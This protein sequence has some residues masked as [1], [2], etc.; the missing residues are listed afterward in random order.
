LIYSVGSK[1]NYEWEDALV[2]I[3]GRNHCEIHV[4]GTGGHARASDSQQKNIYF[5][6]WSIKNSYDKVYNDT[7]ARGSTDDA[8]LAMLSLPESL[9]KLGH[10]NR[11]IDIVK[12][13]CEQCSW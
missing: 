10:Q 8:E 3:V 13:D 2:D 12:L 11:T 7:V 4:F 1:G 6:Q 9:E 5:H